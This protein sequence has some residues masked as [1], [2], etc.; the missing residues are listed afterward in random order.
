LLHKQ[1]LR[2]PFAAVQGSEVG[3]QQ[4]PASVIG[5]IDPE[6]ERPATGKRCLQPPTQGADATAGHQI[7]PAE[8]A[9]GGLS[10]LP[11]REQHRTITGRARLGPEKPC[12]QAQVRSAFAIVRGNLAQGLWRRPLT[13]LLR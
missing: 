12:A 2:A 8:G 6:F 7:E 10:P 1:R 13:R 9:L 3:A 5:V 11:G 4:Q